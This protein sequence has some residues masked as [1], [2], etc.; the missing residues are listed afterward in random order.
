[1]LIPNIE[2]DGLALGPDVLVLTLQRDEVLQVL[3]ELFPHPRLESLEFP[4]GQFLR[5][6]APDGD[7]DDVGILPGTLHLVEVTRPAGRTSSLCAHR[8]SFFFDDDGNPQRKTLLR[9]DELQLE[10]AHVVWGSK[11]SPLILRLDLPKNQDAIARWRSLDAKPEITPLEGFHPYDDGKLH[12]LPSGE[13]LQ[14]DFDRGKK[15]IVLTRHGLDGAPEVTAVPVHPAD[16]HYIGEI[17]GFGV[18][19]DG[20][21]WIH[22]GDELLLFAN[23]LSVPPLAYDLEPMLARR[24]EW[25]NVD[26]YV[27]QQDALWVGLEVMRSRNFALVNLAEIETRAKRTAP[28]PVAKSAQ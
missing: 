27:P 26:I 14:V 6:T 7:V 24:T 13:V 9:G 4:L 16:E 19:A 3:P 15:A 1:M 23:D 25:A 28:R 17:R 8:W 10:N 2:V 11:D 20:R 5:E 18:R 21:L 12:A 22:W